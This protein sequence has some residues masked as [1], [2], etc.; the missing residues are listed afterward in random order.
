[1][2]SGYKDNQKIRDQSNNKKVRVLLYIDIRLKREPV[3]RELSCVVI[4]TI[5]KFTYFCT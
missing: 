3:N 1:M 2:N 4:V 5:G